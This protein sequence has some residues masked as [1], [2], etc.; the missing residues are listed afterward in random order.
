MGPTGSVEPVANSATQAR[1]SVSRE[2]VTGGS[3]ELPP[4]PVPSSVASPL[5]G[6]LHL[7]VS[8]PLEVG[9][10]TTMKVVGRRGQRGVPLRMSSA[11]L[12]AEVRAG[13]TTV[14][15]C[16]DGTTRSH[17]AHAVTWWPAASVWR[18]PVHRAAVPVSQNG[19]RL[20]SRAFEA[21][22]AEPPK[23]RSLR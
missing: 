14:F 22:V 5:P 4:L 19:A 23:G 16:A 10:D 6:R 21:A 8:W 1:G 13:V 7:L 15:T 9:L 18:G 12:E 3:G 20:S 2:R 17:I 11:A